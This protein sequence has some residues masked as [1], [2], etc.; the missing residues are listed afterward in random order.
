MQF[1]RV[2][3][4]PCDLTFLLVRTN[5]VPLA[6]ALIAGAGTLLGKTILHGCIAATAK[7]DAPEHATLLKLYQELHAAP[8][9]SFHEEKTSTRLAGEMRTLGFEVTEKIGGWGIV[10]VLKNGPGRTVLV[11]TD[12]DALPVREL[13]GLPFASTVRVKA[14]D[15]TEVPVMHACGH[16]MHMTCW[17]GTAQW[18]AKH[19][20]AWKGTLVFIGQPAE[21]MGGGLTVAGKIDVTVRVLDQNGNPMGAQTDQAQI[22]RALGNQ[23]KT[24]YGTPAMSR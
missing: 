16:D 6:I 14:A 7:L 22:L 3:R 21:E 10:C 15:G 4:F 13:T 17:L 18:F 12:M 11:R 9:L 23:A 8:E 19:R 20:D 5:L 1:S 2:R 24:T